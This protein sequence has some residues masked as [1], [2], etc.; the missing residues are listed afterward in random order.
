MMQPGTSN[1]APAIALPEDDDV[2]G[3]LVVN[4]IIGVLIGM[5]LPAV[6]KE[7]RPS[8]FAGVSASAS[9]TVRQ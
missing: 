4:A 5:L 1:S 6:Q 3:H 2:Q 8:N 7:P 9:A